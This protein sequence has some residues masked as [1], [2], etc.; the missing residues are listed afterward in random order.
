MKSF[1]FYVFLLF[2]SQ[3]A[4]GQTVAPPQAAAMQSLL[5]DLVDNHLIFG[6]TVRVQSGD[7]K[8]LWVGAAGNLTA[9]T[10]YFI[11]S[12]T[13]LCV[14]AVIL[15]LRAEGKLSLDDPAAKYLSPELVNGIHVLDG[16]DY[17]NMLTIRQLMAHTSGLPDYFQGK[18]EAGKSLEQTLT[19]GQDQPWDEAWVS[20]LVRSHMKPLFIPGTKG[21]AHY[22]DTNYQL[23]G[24]V[25]KAV[26][27]LSVAEAFRQYLFVPIGLKQTYLYADIADKNPAPLYYKSA[28]LVIPQ[29]MASFGAD[30]GVVSTTAETAAFLKAFMT[31][32]YFPITNLAEIQQT[33]NPIFFPMD[34][35]VGIARFL[36]PKYM[37]VGQQLP[38][39]I[40]H[41]G[42]SG[43]F[44]W[45]CPE[46]DWYIT[47][48][49]N[50]IHQPGT[51]FKL[52]VKLLMLL[53]QPGK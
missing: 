24:A 42:L 14:T 30:G 3:M 41:T 51:S 17:S 40:G 43:A 2:F 9:E 26:S 8:L 28:P 15:K 10:P 35:G 5:E 1:I 23:L 49:V 12:T 6:T 31:G 39:L 50:Q 29:A 22:S 18:P 52:L 37:S 19:A 27:G 38:V 34:Y 16:A 45:Y 7:G 33:W 32:V 13:K 21:K 36:I 47:G 44:A 25:I 4:V 46:R 48:T 11:A 53:E 20:E